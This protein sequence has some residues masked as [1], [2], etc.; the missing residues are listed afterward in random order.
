MHPAFAGPD[1]DDCGPNPPMDSAH[2]ANAATLRAGK[3]LEIL[4]LGGTGFF[5]TPV[6]Q[7]A[8]ERGHRLTLLNRGITNPHL[9]PGLQKVRAD[10]LGQQPYAALPRR[11]WD[12]VIDAWKGNPLVVKESTEFL[13]PLAKHYIYISSISVYG[14]PNYKKQ[15]ITE[16]VAFSP[17]RPLPASKQEVI[18]DYTYRK[19]W[20]DILVREI[21]A[22]RHT[23]LR[24]HGLH[25]YYTEYPGPSQFYWASRFQKGGDII[26]PGDGLDHLQGVHIQDVARFAIH[27][28]ETQ[29]TSSF[30]VGKRILWSDYIKTCGALA[31]KD[32]KVHWLSEAQLKEFSIRPLSEMLGYVP[33]SSGPGFFNISDEKAL[34]AGMQYRSDLSLLQDEL[35]GFNRFYPADFDFS[36]C[37]AGLSPAKE[38]A[39]LNK[40]GLIT[41][42]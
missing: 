3:P 41:F 29:T 35:A 6:V 23:V 18:D 14:G 34:K 21:F 13:R 39:V 17:S 7:Y 11:E 15:Q 27:C 40:L 5:G 12:V 19:Q 8:M 31:R 28:A 37:G 30:N 42:K 26:C 24:C 9:F 38:Q 16:T 36:K 2:Y 25:G 10:R 32:F 22:D 4:V 1:E 20:A 33:R